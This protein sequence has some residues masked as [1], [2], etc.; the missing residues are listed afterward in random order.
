MIYFHSPIKVAVIGVCLIGLM[1]SSGC[2][3][4]TATH[5]P[6]S[7][8]TS[9]T[10]TA[11]PVPIGVFTAED[12]QRRVDTHPEEY[13]EIINSDVAILYAYPAPTI[14]WE[15]PIFLIHIPSVS[16]VTLDLN[17]EVFS[18]NY[19]SPEAEEALGELLAD[20]PLIERVVKRAQE[21][22]AYTIIH[23]TGQP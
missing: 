10:P 15:G 16:S 4:A 23:G 1:M 12:M 13:K 2:S 6:L 8:E 20:E 21:I 17:G 9:P 22:G 19:N 14:D 5:Q 7:T 11:A 18:T 3:N